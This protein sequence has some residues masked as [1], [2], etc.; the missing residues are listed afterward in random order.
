VKTGY[1]KSTGKLIEVSDS[2]L[3]EYTA[4]YAEVVERGRHAGYVNVATYTTGSGKTV[5]NHNRY[6]SSVKGH[7]FIENARTNCR[8]E[9]VSVVDQALRQNFKVI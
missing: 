8:K 3:I 5:Q 1:L 9:L 6:Q 2:A 7:H 4:A